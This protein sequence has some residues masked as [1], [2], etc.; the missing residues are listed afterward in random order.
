[1]GSWNVLLYPLNDTIGNSSN[2]FRTLATLN[3]TGASSDVSAPVLVSSTVTPTE[4]NISAGSATTKVTARITD[5]TGTTAPTINASHD[6]GQSQGFGSMTLV[7]GTPQDGTWERTI[8]IPQG[9][10]TGSWNVLLYPLND[11]IGN[12]SNGFRTLATLNVTASTAPL[13]LTGTIPVISGTTRAGY[14]LT[15]TPGTWSPAPVTLTYQ[16]YRSGT[17]ITGATASTYKL[18]TADVSKTITVRVIGRKTGYAAL[19]KTSAPTT[20]I[21]GTLTGTTPVISGT[22]RAGYTLTAT[23]G[24]W[25]PAPVTLTYQW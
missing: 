17:A 11:T 4:L 25:S 1:T 20:A 22:T 13:V 24:T 3:V 21:T 23:P 5:A 9:A 7:S 12:S 2:G 6:T 18:T 14:T 16:W 10:A 15:A 8:T 19:G